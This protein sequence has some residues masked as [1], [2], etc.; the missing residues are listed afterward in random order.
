MLGG[1]R[2]TKDI[3]CLASVTKTDV[4][5]LL[6]GQHGFEAVPQT[7]QDYVAFLWSDKPDKG[8]AVLVEIFCEQFPGAEHSMQ[9]V[10]LKSMAIHGAGKL[11]A[12]ATR[13]KYHDAAD[14]R[15]LG[16]KYG[17][18]IKSLSQGLGL[19]YVG[20][21]IKRYPELERLF[22]RLGVDV[23]QAKEVTKN[24]DLGSLPRPAP[25]DV[26]RGL[27]G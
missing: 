8:N 20:L 14:L 25:G 27:L 26:Q 2:T 10:A 7:R 4:V 12:A 1:F 3:D 13:A 9:G 6:D 22:E 23:L 11:R 24:M 5:G 19:N 16:D 21:A 17:D 15:L 18:E